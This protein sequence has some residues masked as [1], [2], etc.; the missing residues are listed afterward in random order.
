MTEACGDCGQTTILEGDR[1]QWECLTCHAQNA[2][3]LNGTQLYR[4]R[5]AK[6]WDS[7]SKL[8]SVPSSE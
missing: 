7:A 3:F 1:W 2:V 6:R 8:K 4:R 5:G